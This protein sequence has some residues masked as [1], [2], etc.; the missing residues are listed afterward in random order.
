MVTCTIFYSE[1]LLWYQ[2]EGKLGEMKYICLLSILTAL[3]FMYFVIS[4]IWPRQM[5]D[6][7]LK[8][9]TLKNKNTDK[10]TKLLGWDRKKHIIN[11]NTG[12]CCSFYILLNS[13]KQVPDCNISSEVFSLHLCLNWIRDFKRDTWGQ[14]RW[15]HTEKM[16]LSPL[17]TQICVF[18]CFTLAIHNVLS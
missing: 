17:L 11:E 5:D 6:P 9:W 15:N 10:C 13:V 1:K 7:W 2:A 4:T 8:Q 12:T 14:R 16:N 3:F 18:E